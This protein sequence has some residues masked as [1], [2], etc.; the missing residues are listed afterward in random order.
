MTVG[1]IH[2]KKRHI[3]FSCDEYGMIAVL[4]ERRGGIAYNRHARDTGKEGAEIV[5]QHVHV[6][7]FTQNR[8]CIVLLERTT[9]QGEVESCDHDDFIPHRRNH[10]HPRLTRPKPIQGTEGLVLFCRLNDALREEERTVRRVNSHSSIGEPHKQIIARRIV[11]QALRI[12]A[13]RSARVHPPDSPHQGVGTPQLPFPCSF[14]PGKSN[15]RWR[16]MP[17]SLDC[18]SLRLSPLQP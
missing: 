3:A 12:I 11:A 7:S 8:L 4:T 9:Q 18:S 15:C 2:A 14:S 5:L 13:N 10:N 6:V 17:D 16:S 1:E